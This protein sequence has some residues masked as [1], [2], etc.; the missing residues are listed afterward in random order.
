MSRTCASAA[1]EQTSDLVSLTGTNESGK[2]I[3]AWMCRPCLE[4]RKAAKPS[5]PTTPEG[6]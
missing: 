1:C 6:G 2:S 5:A 4:A 3:R